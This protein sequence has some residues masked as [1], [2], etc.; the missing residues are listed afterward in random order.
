MLHERVY[1]RRLALHHLPGYHIDSGGNCQQGHLGIS[2]HPFTT[3]GSYCGREC[4]QECA[5]A[6]RMRMFPLEVL[7]WETI[8]EATLHHPG[9][10]Q[11]KRGDQAEVLM[12]RNWTSVCEAI[13]SPP[14][15][16]PRWWGREGQY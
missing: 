16:P 3:Y 6:Y 5:Q 1:P 11:S 8:Q 2:D 7:G 12:V 15:A 14:G 4:A 13:R 9:W 10:H